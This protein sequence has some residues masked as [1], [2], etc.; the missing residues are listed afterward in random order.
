MLTVGE[1]LWNGAIVTPFLAQ[2]Y[3]SLTQRIEAFRAA[4][5]RAPEQILNARHKLIAEA[6]K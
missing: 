2:A 6:L 3:N 4:G 1:R 5:L